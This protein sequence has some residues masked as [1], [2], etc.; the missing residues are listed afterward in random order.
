MKSAKSCKCR[1]IWWTV[2]NSVQKWW[3]LGKLVKSEKM[4]S[5]MYQCYRLFNYVCHCY[6]Q[7]SASY[8]GVMSDH[9][10]SQFI[11]IHKF[12]KSELS[13]NIVKNHSFRLKEFISGHCLPLIMWKANQTL[14][15]VGSLN[16]SLNHSP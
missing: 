5:Y 6:S 3:Q 1:K 4:Y 2:V 8:P 11:S 15:L 14:N 10:L 9:N 13:L 7:V 16:I 12:I